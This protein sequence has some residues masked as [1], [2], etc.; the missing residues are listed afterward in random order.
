MQKYRTDARLQ[1]VHER[2]ALVA[3]WDDHEFSD[4]CG[5]IAKPTAT[6]ASPTASATMCINPGAGAAPTRP[7]MNSCPPTSTSPPT[8]R[9][10]SRTCA[11]TA[12]CSSAHWP[13]W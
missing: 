12:S 4:D 7:G 8:P 1:A 2:F 10:A 9:P 6:A 3:I 5:P 13:I 11:S